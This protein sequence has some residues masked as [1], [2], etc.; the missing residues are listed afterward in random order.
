MFWKVC[1]PV[2][3]EFWCWSGC[4]WRRWSRRVRSSERPAVIRV[5]HWSIRI[6][7]FIADSHW[8]PETLWEL[9]QQLM[10]FLCSFWFSYLWCGWMP[11]EKGKSVSDE[12]RLRVC[13]VIEDSVQWKNHDMNSYAL[14]V[15]LSIRLLCYLAFYWISVYWLE[16]KPVEFRLNWA[17]SVTILGSSGLG[18]CFDLSHCLGLK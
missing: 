6:W 9:L 5:Q 3:L 15:N 10:N 2:C 1:L 11:L 8:K 14:K 7:G 18:C 12:S 16:H 13:G 4:R 17:D